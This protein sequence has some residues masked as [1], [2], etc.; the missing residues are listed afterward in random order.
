MARRHDCSE[1]ENQ[2]ISEGEKKEEATANDYSMCPNHLTC[3]LSSQRQRWK[4][5]P[6][7]GTKYLEGKK[8]ELYENRIHRSQ[9][10]IE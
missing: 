10:E 4:I 7:P 8:I 1:E 2:E 6:D 3:M 9:V 5:N